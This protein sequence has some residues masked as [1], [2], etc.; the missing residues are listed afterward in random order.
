LQRRGRGERRATL[1]GGIEVRVGVVGRPIYGLKPGFLHV[2][3]EV[4]HREDCRLEGRR[5]I[6]YM[7]IVCSIFGFIAIAVASHTA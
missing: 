3:R 1:G 2:V 7:Y 4:Q 5:I 6:Y